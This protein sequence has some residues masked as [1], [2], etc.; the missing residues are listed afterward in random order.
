M[1]K[2]PKK[3]EEK[4]EEKKAWKYKSSQSKEKIHVIG[5]KENE[6]I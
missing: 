5:V 6:K 3:H 2:S 4:I 1:L